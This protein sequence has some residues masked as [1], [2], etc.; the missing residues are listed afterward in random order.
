MEEE[1]DQIGLI[2][3]ARAGYDPRH[4]LRFWERFA[5]MT[6]DQEPPEFLSTHPATESRIEAIRKALPK[7][8]KEYRKAKK[9]MGEG[10]P[11]PTP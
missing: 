3:M 5:E 1:A 7:A 8:M 2:Y 11:L 6:K 4:A 10:K 9:Q